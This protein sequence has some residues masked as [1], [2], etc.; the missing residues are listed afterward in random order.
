MARYTGPSCKLCRRE[1]VKLFL[2]GQRCHTSKCALT[3][4]TYPPGMHRWRRGKHSE[5]STQL[6]EKQKVKRFYGVLEAQFRRYFK[7]A[8]R[9][10]GP[11]GLEL[12]RMFELR[13][14]NVV[15]RLGFASSRSE[16]RQL[17]RHRHFAVNG[18][19]VDIPS[20]VCKPDDVIGPRENETAEKLVKKN[21][22]TT[23]F[24]TVPSW[25]VVDDA[26]TSGKVLSI[27]ARDE[28][29]IEA[30]TNLIIELLSK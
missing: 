28:F 20:Y 23:R 12:M 25:L 19:H 16:A 29:S 4:R 30:D 3:R 24:N 5:Y 10:S 8:E 26:D 27:P 1:G 7:N 2:K 21:L 9:K 14:D 18:K 22:E 13:L 17:I 15:T 6:R 11:T